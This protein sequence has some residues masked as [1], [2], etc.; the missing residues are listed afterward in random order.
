MYQPPAA[1]RSSSAATAASEA[2][3]QRGLDATCF[4][5][6]ADE[7]SLRRRAD[8]QRVG[9]HRLGDVL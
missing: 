8:F 9:P 5:R 3:S 4:A 6:S 2:E 1:T 7:P